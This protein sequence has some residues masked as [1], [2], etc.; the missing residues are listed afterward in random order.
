M[1]NALIVSGGS[2]QGSTLIKGLSS[3]PCVRL[4]LADCY[5]DNINKYECDKFYQVPL[6]CHGETFIESIR[7]IIDEQD[8]HIIF[9]A[10]EFELNLLSKN[11]E[12]L[13]RRGAKLAVSDFSLNDTLLNKIN[14]YQ[15]LKKNGFALLDF[16]Q[17]Q[18]Q[19]VAYPIIG[20]PARGFGGKGIIVIRN[21]DEKRD[22]FKSINTA[23]YLWLPFLEDFE[24]FSIDFA[25]SFKREISP[26]VIRRRIRTAGGFAVI[27]ESEHDTYIQQQ[28]T[29]LA[30]VIENNGGCG[31]FNVQ[32]IRYDHNC[33]HFSDINPRVGTSSVFTLGAGVNLPLFMCASLGEGTVINDMRYDIGHKIKMVRNLSEKWLKLLPKNKIKGIVFDLDDTLIDQKTWIFDKLSIIHAKHANQLP[34]REAFMMASYQCIEEGKRSNLIDELKRKFQLPERLRDALIESF[35]LAHPKRII[36][37]KD[38][39]INLE[40]FKRLGLKLGL[41]TDNPVQSQ[42]QKVERL[43]CANLFDV[44]L[45]ARDYNREKPDKIVFDKM[46][47]KLGVDAYE[48]AMVGD[49]L[50]RDCYGALKA[51]FMMAYF[52]ERK[53]TFFNFNQEHFKNNINLPHENIVKIAS[54]NDLYYSIARG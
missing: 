22:V 20:K 41:L 10:T 8:I 31:I 50:Y 24:E 52:I 49:N 28:V 6:I 37:F 14:T 5:H 26:V 47:E 27:T 9:P 19:D 17:P 33:Y 23:D 48:L 32:V 46:V 45:Y 53:G 40:N 42:K 38:V 34:D 35:R 54:L 2:L 43:E 16:V 15:F 25:I 51:G 7:K 30:K 11:K 18:T 1:I 3:S 39:G 29:L 4:H 12:I 21:E 44:I 13:E 36:V